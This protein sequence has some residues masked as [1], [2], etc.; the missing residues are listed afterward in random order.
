MQKLEIREFAIREVDTEKR[1]VTG[2]A[3]PWD[4]PTNIAGLYTETIARGAVQD[5]TDAMLFWRHEDPIGKVTKTRD[6]D[7]GW[8]ITA[9]ISDTPRGN[10]AYTLL[11]DEVIKKFSIGFEPIEHTEDEDG[12]ITRT[13]I[14]V[15]EV[16][17]VPLP[18]YEGASISEVRENQPLPKEKTMA[19]TVDS[20]GLDEVRETVETLERK[21]ATLQVAPAAEVE[22]T[23]SAGEVLKALAE[24]D[25]STLRAYTGGTTADSVVK[26]GWVGDLTRLIDEAAPLRNAFATGNLPK[27]GNFVEYA[28]LKSD[29]SDAGVQAAEGDD[30]VY[31]QVSVE[32]ETAPVKTVGGYTQLS[33]QEI[34]R[35][36][37]NILDANLRGQAIA[38]GKALNGLFRT[39][40]TTQ[41]AAQVT[42]DNTVELAAAGDYTDFLN[43]AVDAA[44][45][46]QDNG[47]SMDGMIV[48]S[49]TFKD[50]IALQGSDGRPVFLVTGQGTNNVGAVSVGSLT[51]DIAGIR[52]ILDPKLAADNNAFFNRNAIREYKSPIVRLQD[53][54]IINLSKDFSLYTYTALAQEIPFGIVPLVDAA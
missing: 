8:E 29:D 22:D 20:T 47:L 7:A 24:G 38:V 3:V 41:H 49:A 4:T 14:R 34:E 2:I 31:G 17:L 12:N 45:I 21:F 32:T 35:S 43:A 42:A 13:K 15:R 46:F 37:V 28:Q 9:T 1:E 36:S 19:E 51:G 23:R 16:S 25:E 53:D 40:Y 50:L 10:E 54:N 27:E 33:R 44:G 18:A 52:I 39:A 5:S 11:R 26:N 6:T 30:L 48:D